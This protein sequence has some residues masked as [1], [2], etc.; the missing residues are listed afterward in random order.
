MLPVRDQQIVQHDP[1]RSR[2]FSSQR[3]FGRVRSLCPDVTPAVSDP[4]DVRVH[5]NAG[6]PETKRH[7]EIRRLTPD[8]R[9]GEQLI[10]IVRDAAPITP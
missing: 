4:V 2:K 8:P 1:V 3:L 7:D 6:L 9:K 5:A 10:E